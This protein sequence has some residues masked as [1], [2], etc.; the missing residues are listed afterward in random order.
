MFS[1]IVFTYKVSVTRA[2]HVESDFPF[3]N[4]VVLNTL[5]TKIP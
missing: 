4:E 5:E 3:Q 2:F 1:T